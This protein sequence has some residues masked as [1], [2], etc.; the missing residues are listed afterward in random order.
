MN[1]WYLFYSTLQLFFD[2]SYFEERRKRILQYANY[3]LP[4]YLAIV[5]F[6]VPSLCL[7]ICIA[8]FV[9]LLGLAQ[10]TEIYNQLLGRCGKRQVAGAKIGL[11]HNLGL[12]GA[13]VVALYKRGF[14]QN[15]YVKR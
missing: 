3:I 5:Y 7:H 6:H 8:F 1:I 4:R 11:Q 9:Y 2:L 14:P 10:C 12:G 13:V 15:G